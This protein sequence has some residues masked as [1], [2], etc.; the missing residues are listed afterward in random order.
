MAAPKNT[1]KEEDLEQD[2]VGEGA[3]DTDRDDAED[4][5]GGVLGLARLFRQGSAVEGGGVDVEPDTRL[6]DVADD[7]TEHQGE[8]RCAGE[9]D[10]RLDPDAAHGLDVADGG[11]AGDD[12]QEDQRGNDHLDQHDEAVAKRPQ[13]RTQRGPEVPDEHPCYNGKCKL[14]KSDL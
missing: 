2:V 12:H 1:E 3:D 4:E 7:Q 13:G 11:D 9:V 5:A 10:Q 8:E 6:D 14:E